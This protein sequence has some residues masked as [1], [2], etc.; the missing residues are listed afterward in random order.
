MIFGIRPVIEAIK[1]GKEID[2]L[3][4]RR[5][6]RGDLFL[7]MF[8][9]VREHNIP[10]QFVPVEKLDRLAGA[11]HQGVV[12]FLAL[13]G[14][15]PLENIIPA[16]YE[17]GKVPLIMVLDRITDVRNFGAI[18]RTAECAGVDALV[19]PVKGGAMVNA[20]AIK[21]SAGAL[22][23][24]PVCRVEDLGDSVRFLKDSGLQVIVAS[25]KARDTMYRPDYTRPTVIIMGSEEDGVSAPLMEEANR[26]VKIPMQGTIESL[27]VSVSAALLIYEAVRQRIGK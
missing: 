8:Q 19:V 16:L 26:K 9:L 14:Y 15:Q 1:A 24:I 3:L 7:E 21:T 5:N 18:A 20:D 22:Y 6:L 10:Y 25:E 12:G 27:N 13:I 4:I 17:E 23:K 11:T 2:K